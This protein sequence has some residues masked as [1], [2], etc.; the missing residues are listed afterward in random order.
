MTKKMTK[1]EKVA[2]IKHEETKIENKKTGFTGLQFWDK[3]AKEPIVHSYL[4]PA[5][6]NDDG[7]MYAK[8]NLKGDYKKDKDTFSIIVEFGDTGYEMT[9]RGSTNSLG[10]VYTYPPAARGGN[11]RNVTKKLGE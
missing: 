10:R 7:T 8:I 11:A 5:N 9:F 3:E 1:T 4:I 2:V 6:V